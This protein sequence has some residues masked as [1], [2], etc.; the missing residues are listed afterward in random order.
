M[1]A[2]GGR[3]VGRGRAPVIVAAW[4]AFGEPEAARFLV[5]DHPRVRPLTPA[6]LV[7]LAGRCKG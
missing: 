6:A 7:F 4:R 5:I 2:P 1:L 3:P